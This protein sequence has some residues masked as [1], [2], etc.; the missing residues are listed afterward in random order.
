MTEYECGPAQQC[1]AA[2]R[3]CYSIQAKIN[4]LRSNP[5]TPNISPMKTPADLAAP[6]ASKPGSYD[7]KNSAYSTCL[8][9]PSMYSCPNCMSKVTAWCMMASWEWRRHPLGTLQCS[10]PWG[11]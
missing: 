5:A 8:Q 11:T 10:R 7:V 9:L 1:S 3:R 2:L 6:P 4:D